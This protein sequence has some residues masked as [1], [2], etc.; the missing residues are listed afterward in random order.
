MV[1]DQY[2]DLVDADDPRLSAEYVRVLDDGEEPPVVLVGVVHDHPASVYRARTVVDAVEPSALAL[3]L[4]DAL[5]PLFTSYAADGTTGGEMA[6][7]IDAADAADT[8]VVGIDAPDVGSARALLATFR[9]N[10]SSV[11]DV[12][13]TLRAF[14]QLT[15]ETVRGRLRAAGIPA[16]WLG[17]VPGTSQAFDASS[18]DAPSEQAAH[19]SAHVRQSTSLLRTFEVPAPTRLLDDAR[20]QY[21][22]DRLTALRGESVVGVVGYSHLDEVARG[23]AAE[24]AGRAP[25]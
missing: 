15:V 13:R 7:A 5:V 16:G 3:E 20:E 14:G 2:D 6:A 11:K 4:P 21:M 10:E 25:R 17:K 23:L 12:V 9:S 8:D 22:V 1:G 19:E 24:R 18:A